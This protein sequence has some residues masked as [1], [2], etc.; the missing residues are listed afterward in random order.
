VERN[1]PKYNGKDEYMSNEFSW[2][3]LFMT[4]AVAAASA[5]VVKV[6]DGILSD[7]QLTS[8]EKLNRLD[9]LLRTG[10]ISKE[11]WRKGRDSIMNNFAHSC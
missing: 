5:T 11:E 4:V 10:E 1:A 7:S 6:V 3:K 9:T 8:Q 2:G